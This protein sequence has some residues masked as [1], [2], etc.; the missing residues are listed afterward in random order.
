M[1]LKQIIY[2]L[3]HGETELNVK[4]RY[5]GELDSPLTS[6]GIEQVKNNAKLLKVLI[7]NPKEWEFISSPLGRAQQ[8]TD[9]VCEVIGYDRNK[10]KM[11]DRLKE[12]NVGKWAGLTTKE[13]EK[14]W[15]ELMENTN[16]HNW[17]FNS[18]SGESYDS[19]VG[20]VSE[21]LRSIQNKEKV[22][23]MSHG[24]TGRIIRG[25]YQGITKDQ[26][27]VLEVS[28]NTF[29]KLYDKQVESFCS[30]YDEF[31]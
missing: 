19:V 21:W 9:I 26:A 4:G 8:S 1:S 13:I 27:L 17:Y 11:D 31:Y 28:Q 24:L 3:R 6:D 7:D 22:I 29:F 18:P 14:S 10:V 20:R 30:E 15:P 16:N 23:V 5:Q 2:L 12:V 25:V